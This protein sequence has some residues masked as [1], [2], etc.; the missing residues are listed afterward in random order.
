[1]TFRKALSCLFYRLRAFGEEVFFPNTPPK[2]VE[3]LVNVFRAWKL[4]YT[5]ML[6]RLFFYLFLLYQEEG[7]SLHLAIKDLDL[8]LSELE[9]TQGVD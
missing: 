2:E 5:W 6:S 7:C 3:I 8:A 9:D 1:M 4:A